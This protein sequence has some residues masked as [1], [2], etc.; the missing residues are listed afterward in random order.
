MPRSLQDSVRNSEEGRQ[1][2][3]ILLVYTHAS[4]SRFSKMPQEA[5]IEWKWA[6]QM[7]ENHVFPSVFS[8]IRPF[9]GV[10]ERWWWGMDSN[11]RTHRGQIYSLM[12]LATS[13]PHQGF[14]EKR[15]FGGAEGIRTLDP[16]VAN[17]MLY[18]LSYRPKRHLLG[19]RRARTVSADWRMR[20]VFLLLFPPRLLCHKIRGGKRVSTPFSSAPLAGGTARLPFC[21]ESPCLSRFGFVQSSLGPY[22]LSP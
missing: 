22:I 4:V 20:K 14:L 15:S 5:Q 17:V 13:L 18:Q 10:L 11:H 19:N 16:Y 21:T 12:R 8:R 9:S 3:V 1:G 7:Q 6:G 2:S